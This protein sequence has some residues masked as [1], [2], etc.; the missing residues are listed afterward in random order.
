MKMVLV[1]QNTMPFFVKLL[2]STSS[3]SLAACE[4]NKIKGE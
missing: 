4:E 1:T 3:A 2:R